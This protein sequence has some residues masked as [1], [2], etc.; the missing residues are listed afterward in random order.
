[1]H[2]ELALTPSAEE[3]KRALVDVAAEDLA[4]AQTT[5]NTIAFGLTAVVEDVFQTALKKVG[6]HKAFAVVTKKEEEEK[7]R[8]QK[9]AHARAARSQAPVL[10]ELDETAFAEPAAWESDFATYFQLCS[11]GFE[12]EVWPEVQRLHAARGA[13]Q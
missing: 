2:E 12:G 8:L 13:Q 9:Q 1:M 11:D 4:D 6:L 3:V 7:N 10:E 5:W